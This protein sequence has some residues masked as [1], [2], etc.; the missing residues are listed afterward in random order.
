MASTSGTVG[1]YS[2]T[3][4]RVI[5]H[6]LRRAGYTP[7]QAGSEWLQIA[8]DLLFLQLSEYVNAGMP[9]WTR[10]FGLLGVTVGSPE[11]ACPFGTVD[12]LHCYWRILQPYRGPAVTSGGV[13]ASVLFGGQPNPDVIIPGPNAFVQVNFGS[14]TEID[15]VGILPGDAN[16][17][18]YLT[19]GSGNIITD[20]FGNAISTGSGSEA[21]WTL[22][23]YLTVST[24]GV[25]WYPG[26]TFPSTTFTAGQWSYFDLDPSITTQYMRL[27]WPTADAWQINQIN[28]ALSQGQDIEI[29]PL[30]ID[31]Y[32]NL[33]NKQF[34][35]DRPNSG[36]VDRQVN[37]P[38]IKIW[39]TPNLGAFYNGTVSAL[40][41]RYIQDPGAMTNNIEV[42]LRW[43]EGIVA[44]L[45][46]RLMD[47]LPDPDTS[48][49]ASYFTL[50]AKTQRR[51]ILEAA[52]TK[53][54]ALMWSE[55]RVRAPVRWAPNMRAYT[56]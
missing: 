22:T 17:G 46:V 53:S 25:I 49:Q 47:E 7:E 9:L 42:P 31:D 44:R 15:T 24:D 10:E 43:Y 52:A 19:D 1:L 2:F 14:P 40:T 38:I 18:P 50:M 3:Q 39:P 6:A 32:Y 37:E 20:E 30:N 45:G 28:F 12:V 54:E 21:T 8:Q 23:P 11:V 26:Q 41:R 51:Q 35:T 55:E 56:R 33:P 5:D 13:D 16:F 4:R 34:Q 48:A 36:Y 27:V 29:G